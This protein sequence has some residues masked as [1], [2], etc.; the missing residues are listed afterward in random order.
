MAAFIDLTGD[1]YDRWTVLG[2]AEDDENGN[3]RWSCICTCGTRAIVYG[4]N[5]RNG[6]SRSCG[7]LQTERVRDRHTTHG[8]SRSK[9]YR[10]W[11]SMKARCDKEGNSRAPA[12][13]DRWAESFE[14]FVEDM[15][16]APGKEYN[17][18][19]IDSTKGYT[20]ENCRWSDKPDLQS[21]KSNNR[22]L[23]LN[24]QSM[25]LSK[26]ARSLGMS[27]QALHSRLHKGW[28]IEKALTTPIKH[29]K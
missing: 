7:C 5:L 6:S 29:P 24:G 16:P 15:G 10:T 8:M 12:L 26:W 20:P 13:C 1:V 14:S 11:Y 18:D 28:S 3:I 23:E 9:E 19:L 17:M 22:Y 21:N 25:T 2:R 27:R 4:G